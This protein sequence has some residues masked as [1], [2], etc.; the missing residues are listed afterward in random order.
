MTATAHTLSGVQRAAVLVVALGVETAGRLLPE[1]DDDEAERLSVEVARLDRVP[2]EAV[3]DVLAAYRSAS[4]A[5]VV[6]ET[7]GGLDT[8]R[9]LIQT[10]LDEDRARTVLPRV[11]AKMEGTGFS[12]AQAAPPA[13]LAA[14]LTLEH[15]QTSAVVLSQLP[16]RPAADVL[17]ELPEGVRSDVI[18]RLTALTPPPSSRLAALDAALRRRF[19]PSDAPTGPSGVKRAADILMQ[20]GR[21]TGDAV[22]DR[23]RTDAPELADEIR[24]LLFVFDDLA[25]LDDRVLGQIVSATD[26]GML[27]AALSGADEALRDRVFGCVSERVGAALR[28]EMELAGTPDPRALEDAQRTVVGVALELAEAGQVSLEATPA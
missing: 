11:E 22:L 17:A 10:G 8:A 28:E 27:A 2:A 16:A 26:Q 13:E 4:V 24:G 6:P 25:R 7:V 19:G 3:A 1:L 9:T 20:S 5:P 18:R 21:S 23:L 12:L 15:P 14:F